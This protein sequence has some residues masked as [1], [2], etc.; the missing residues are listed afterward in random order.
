MILKT[1]KNKT[2]GRERFPPAVLTLG[3]FGAAVLAAFG[4]GALPAAFVSTFFSFFASFASFFSLAARTACSLCAFLTSGFWFL[5]AMMSARVAP[6]T[7]LMNFCVLRVLFLEVSSTMPLR[8]L[9]RYNSVQ[10][11]F[12]GLRFRA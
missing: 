10:L 6:V 8:C 11:I 5:L 3:A 7:A 1:K 9:R 12:L 2:I 4:L